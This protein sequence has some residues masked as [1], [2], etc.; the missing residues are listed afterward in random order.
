MEQVDHIKANGE[1]WY[2]RKQYLAM[3]SKKQLI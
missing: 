2:K 1:R 3:R